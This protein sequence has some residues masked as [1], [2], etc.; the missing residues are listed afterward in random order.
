MGAIY[1]ALLVAFGCTQLACAAWRGP[2]Y[3]LGWSGGAFVFAG[4]AHLTRTPRLLGKRA[5]GRLHPAVLALLLPYF[6]FTWGRWLVEWALLRERPWDEVAPGL[7]LGRWPG[8][9]DLPSGVDLVVDLAAEL[10]AVRPAAVMEYVSLST[11]DT[12]APEPRAFDAVARRVASRTTPVYVHCALGHGRAATLAAATLLLRGQGASAAE[13][14][15][16]LQAARP[17]V[18]LAPSQKRLVEAFARGLREWQP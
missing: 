8:G 3:L 11:L 16:R 14:V 10:P 18:R 1:G 12:T 5:D 4:L 13:V 6:A 7:F 9:V 17:R 15:A 2:L